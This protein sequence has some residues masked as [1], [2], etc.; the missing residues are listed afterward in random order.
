MLDRDQDTSI[1]F[2]GEQSQQSSVLNVWLGEGQVCGIGR[3]EGWS[4]LRQ[5]Q[6]ELPIGTGVAI[7]KIPKRFR[8]IVTIDVAAALDFEGWVTAIFEAL[9]ER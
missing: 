5:P 1:R 9:R 8:N 2:V 6:R 3:R 4:W 7:D